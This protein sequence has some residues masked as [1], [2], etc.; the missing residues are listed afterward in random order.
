MHTL[1]IVGGIGPESTIDYY[2]RIIAA[3]RAARPDGL[4]GSLLRPGETPYGL[5]YVYTFASGKLRAVA[6]PDTY[7]SLI[8]ARGQ[9]DWESSGITDASSL[10]GK[11]WWLFDVQMHHTSVGQPDTATLTPNA[12][13]GESAQLLRI[14]IP[15][16]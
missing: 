14:Y 2:R 13:T 8:P 15:G 1:G 6:R 7:A 10:W 5:M 16:T 3:Y 11:G 12:T 4:S 9:G